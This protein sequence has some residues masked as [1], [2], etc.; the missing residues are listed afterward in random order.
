MSITDEQ[1]TRLNAEIEKAQAKIKAYQQ[2]LTRL[3]E[4]K[5]ALQDRA[6]LEK[7]NE[8]APSYQDA[9]QM[10]DM[11]AAGQHTADTGGVTDEKKR[12]EPHYR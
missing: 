4:K 9:Q 10:L 7:I 6:L 12:D 2:K 8:I 5:K 11:L 3:T 1:L